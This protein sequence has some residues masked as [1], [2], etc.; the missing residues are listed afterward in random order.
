MGPSRYVN[1]AGPSCLVSP[2]LGATIHRLPNMMLPASLLTLICALLFAVMARATPTT[3]LAT[4][5]HIPRHPDTCFKSNVY[6]LTVQTGEHGDRDWAVA[7]G[8]PS[9][10][11]QEPGLPWKTY[12]KPR[13]SFSRGQNAAHTS[14][15]RSYSFQWEIQGDATHVMSFRLLLVL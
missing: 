8:K 1:L 12:G 10:I 4:R 6:C 15:D 5:A 9:W 7:E 3:E 11:Q 2:V 14:C 13:E